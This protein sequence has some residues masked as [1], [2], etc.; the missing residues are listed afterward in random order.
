METGDWGGIA[1]K[2]MLEPFLI[3]RKK[4]I[5]MEMFKDL[6]VQYLLNKSIQDGFTNNYKRDIDY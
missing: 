5:C 4:A 2:I 6:S 1:E 3:R